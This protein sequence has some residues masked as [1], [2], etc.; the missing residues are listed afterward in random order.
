MREVVIVDYARSA[1][2]KR[3]GA[4]RS[5]YASTLGGLV[6]RELV[7]K[8][9]ILERGRLDSV[10]GG[11]CETDAEAFTPPRY[12]A[13][14]A[15]LPFEIPAT[16]VEMAC[17]TAITAINHAAWKII[18]GASDVIIAGGA[19]SQSTVPAR[20]SRWEEPYKGIDPH[21]MTVRHSPF[22]EEDKNQIE[23]ADGYS[24][25]WGF[26]REECDQFA[27]ES[28]QRLARAYAS[29][30][31]GPEI[32]PITIPATRK[33]PAIIVD[34]DE[35]PRPDVTPEQLAKLPP[36]YE[37]GTTT[38]GNASGIND[39]AAFV[40]MMTR[41]KAEEYGYKPLARWVWGNDIGV[42]PTRLDLAAGQVMGRVLKEAK[43]RLSDMDVIECN[44]AFASQ[45]LGAIRELERLT[46]ERVDRAR[47][48]PNGG[49][50]AIGHPNAAS[51][52]RITMFAMRQLE[53]TGGKYGLIS[54]CCG[55]GQGTCTLIENLV[56]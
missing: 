13:Q 21:A 37:G 44:E 40:L 24:R 25:I 29:G 42:R 31:I 18:V 22:D 50:I 46:G 34:R 43:L 5:F 15:G 17:G 51:G 52:A 4:L 19:E 3:G 12:M 55:T 16:T 14:V 48:N 6:L 41:E 36:I 26:S 54:S 30:V 1:F 27:Y 32:V 7:K 53:A 2:G 33:T 56:R 20:F 35:H 45:N 39:G 38:A 8:S 28:Q 49:A 47:W 11:S 10:I 23:N 9:G